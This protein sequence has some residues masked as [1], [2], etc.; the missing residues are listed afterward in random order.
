MLRNYLTIALRNLSKQ[1]LYTFVNIFGLTLGLACFILILRYVQYELNFDTFH[2]KAD[3]IHRVVQRQ[4]GN[5]Y[6][7][8]DHF[9][10]TPAPL[11]SA[12][13]REFPEVPV[14]TTINRHSTLISLGDQH[15]YEDGLWG[16]AHLFD[17]FTFPM[18]QGNP[19][20]ALIEPNS[21]VLTVSLAEKIF[22]D[23]EPMGQTLLRQNS[24]TYT[25]TGVIEDV[26]DYSHFTFTFVTSLVSQEYYVRNLN[27][28]VWN[29]NSWYTYFVLQEGVDVAQLQNKMPLFV[30]KYL[31][32]E[33]DEE[34]EL[35]QYYIQALR[36]IHLYSH[37]NFEIAAN[38]DIKY[39]Y[40][41]S[42]IAVVILLLACVNYM[43]LAV[44]RS[45]KRAKE[46]GLRKVVGA[47]RAQLIFQF[48]GESVLLAF[49]GLGFALAIV[50]LVLPAFG[51]WVER[52]L[53]MDY[54]TNGGLILALLVAT[55][56][57]GALSGSYPAI[58]MSSL[59]PTS[60]LKGSLD[61]GIGRSRLRSTL[62]VA[63]Y[64]ISIVLVV[65]SLII[66]QQL[67]FI[68]NKEIGYNREHVIVLNIQDRE[69]RQNYATIKEELLRNPNIMSVA[70]SGHLP[71]QISSQTTVRGWEGSAEEDELP[72]YRTD[73]GY[74][75]LDVFEID[76]AE[77]RNFSRDIASDSVA[78][79]INQTA[80]KAMGWDSGVGKGFRLWRTEGTIVGVVK[81]FHM[82][83]LH[84]PI[85]P[86]LL[87]LDPDRVNYISAKIRAADL[88]QTIAYIEQTLATFTPYPFEY[89]F[90]DESFDKL[91][92]TEMKL[93][94]IFG[95]FTLL[96]LLIASLGLFGIAAFTA[97]QRTKEIGVRKVLGAS[98][99]GLMVLLS[100]E[101]A[102]LV[103]VAFVIGAPV[104]YFAMNRWLEDFAY[105]VS[106]GPGVFLVAMLAVLLIAWLSVSYQ[107]LKAARVNPVL[108]LQY[109]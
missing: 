5:V 15:F 70:S 71:T 24:E 31:L 61:R 11:A 103:V 6:L 28:N 88:P 80:A 27:D 95:Y 84:M 105:R 69:A 36:E 30:R 89:E 55:I 72:I 4:P 90:L 87:I 98:V 106:I 73:V 63:Q 49:L 47:R 22:G 57:V 33:D 81:D 91:Y 42:A 12:L 10:V 32:D 7:G 68:Q 67:R 56:V 19:S 107:A 52:D 86:L 79:L 100:K 23:E 41:F 37:T 109:E 104:A 9:A 96:A 99:P 17:V 34:D 108:S 29:N 74:D 64:A 2:E 85:Q 101:F 51:Q 66:Y 43:N 45:M 59:Q 54:A 8:S 65:G 25:V 60:V 48:I 40:M 97:E 93:G 75:F 16:D 50:H 39:I 3:Q 76:V 21:I 26:P 46:V 58:F 82:H 94:E 44:A 62:I 92:K 102:R 14:A 83:S 38:N 35:N 77:G 20:T 18:L 53:Y 78:F 1:K 13:V